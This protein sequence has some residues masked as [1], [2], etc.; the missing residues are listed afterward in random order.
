MDAKDFT[1]NNPGIKLGEFIEEEIPVQKVKF[2]PDSKRVSVVTQMEKQ[3]TMYID[4][5]KEKLRCRSGEHVFRC[6]DNGR[7]I[8]SCTKC[9]FSRQVYPTTYKYDNGK[10]IHKITGKII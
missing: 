2:D 10:L 9:P 6:V 5:P 8:F 3:K 7:Y 4:A 1:K